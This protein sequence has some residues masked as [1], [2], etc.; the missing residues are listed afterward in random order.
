[1]KERCTQ[2]SV[3]QTWKGYKKN[4]LDHNGEFLGRLEDA[5]KNSMSIATAGSK[6]EGKPFTRFAVLYRTNTASILS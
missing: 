5:L 6:R 1:M 2:P 4:F 3:F